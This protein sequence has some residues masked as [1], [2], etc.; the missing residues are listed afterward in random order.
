MSKTYIKTFFA[1][2]MALLT[3][4]VAAQNY[5]DDALLFSQSE[6]IGTA[7]V[8]SIGGAQVALGGDLGTFGINPA[9]VA[10]YRSSDLGISFMY[11][12]TTN[13]ATYLGNNTDDPF[14]KITVPQFG[15]VIANAKSDND[16]SF[17]GRWNNFAF[18][19][20]YLRTHDFN[21]EF[22]YNGFNETSSI[23]S[24]FADRAYDT[25]GGAGT[26]DI[27][28][29][30]YLED[31]AF[32]AGVIT[33]A[34]V[35]E[36][37]TFIGLSEFGNVQQYREV[38][39]K[40]GV[41]EASITLGGN[42]GNQLFLGAALTY[43]NVRQENETYYSEYD[44]NDPSYPFDITEFDY[45][46]TYEQRGAGFNAKFGA[47]YVPVKDIRLGLSVQSPSFIKF[48]EDNS[49]DIVTLE[50]NGES[51]SSGISGNF[52]YN[53]RTPMKINAGLAKFFG[54]QGFLSADV[55]FLDYSTMDFDSDFNETDN[56]VNGQIE[57]RFRNAVN[58][59]VGGEYKIDLISL[60]LGYAYFGNPYENTEADFSR[61]YFTAGLGYRYNNIYLDLAGIYNQSNTTQVPYIASGESGQDVSPVADIEQNRLGVMLTVGT[62]F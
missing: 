1:I 18:G 27:D 26:P 30:F 57:E 23:T 60:R 24:F 19:I 22:S 32:A 45:L 20:S 3:G 47:I 31:V 12:N 29:P 13:Q 14:G 43:V 61:D 39:T 48:E 42:Y 41:S 53:I 44:I 58:F 2:S 9:G 52:D 35:D 16:G 54:D 28:N 37:P 59:R 36:Q 15:L 4:S 33:D 55:E 62:R 40:G 10:F 7:R 46:R 51:Y 11:N 6:L 5:E 21:N 38:S 49:D 25:Y 50:S 8:K 17:N 56:I 34:E